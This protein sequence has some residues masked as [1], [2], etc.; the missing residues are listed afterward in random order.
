MCNLKVF[1]WVKVKG[2]GN[3]SSSTTTPLSET[4][5]CPTGTGLSLV[6]PARE[7]VHFRIGSKSLRKAHVWV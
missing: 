3:P 1:S 2:S 4:S 7:I 5:H 6:V